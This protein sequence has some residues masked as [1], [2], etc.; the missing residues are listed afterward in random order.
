[1]LMELDELESGYPKMTLAHLYD[2]IYEI[3]AS[4]DKD[5]AEA[6]LETA[7]FRTRRKELQ[8]PHQCCQS[9]QE[10]DQLACTQG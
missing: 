9:A 10:R 5:G 4:I 1:M 7:V 6:Y 2:V 3:E 8:A